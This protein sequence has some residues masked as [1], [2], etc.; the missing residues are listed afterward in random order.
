MAR[1]RWLLRDRLPTVF[2][3]FEVRVEAAR[4]SQSRE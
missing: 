3:T 4:A 2:G 1:G